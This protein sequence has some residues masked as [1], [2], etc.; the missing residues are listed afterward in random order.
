MNREDRTSQRKKNLWLIPAF[1][2]LGLLIALLTAANGR[3]YV[4]AA[5]LGAQSEDGLWQDVNETMLRV[6][7]ERQI[8]PTAYR[9]LSLD[10]TKLNTLLANAPDSLAEAQTGEVILSLPLPDG[11]YGRFQI[12]QTAVMHPDLAA[13]FPEIQTYVGVGLDDP[14]AYAR[15]DTTPKGFHAMILSGSET[16]F[17]DP[18]S[19][20]DTGIYISTTMSH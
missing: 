7:G 4:S 1:V 8:V 14:T 13:K 6:A 18:Y 3:Q 5:P 19:S 17:I 11:S 10:W 2:I 12:T 16:V 15:L 20:E 9:V